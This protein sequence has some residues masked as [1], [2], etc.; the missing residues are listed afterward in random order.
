MC[1]TRSILRRPTRRSSLVP[2]A[3]GACIPRCR[4]IEQHGQSAPEDYAPRRRGSPKCTY[5]ALDV[6]PCT[7]VDSS[8]ECAD[9]SRTPLLAA[10]YEKALIMLLA[11][12][13][14]AAGHVRETR[15]ES[16]LESDGLA[17]YLAA[18]RIEDSAPTSQ[19]SSRT[20]RY[21]EV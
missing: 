18:R 8:A 1:E 12:S 2:A 17:A 20:E 21:P 13:S 14:G 7:R 6:R 15:D 19:P 5:P 9:L 4:A 10:T 11:S 3:R 16:F